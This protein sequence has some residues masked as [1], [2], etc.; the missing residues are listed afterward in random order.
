MNKKDPMNG[1]HLTIYFQIWYSQGKSTSAASVSILE[2][3]RR[4]QGR[5]TYILVNRE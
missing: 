3:P 5:A 4:F 2:S 1:S